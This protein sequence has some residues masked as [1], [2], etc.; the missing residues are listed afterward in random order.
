MWRDRASRDRMNAGVI[1]LGVF[2]VQGGDNVV[3]RKVEGKAVVQ[4]R[5]NRK[6]CGDGGGV[7]D[8]G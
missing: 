5:G 3:L 4:V 1:G 7:W 2:C 8:G 6:C